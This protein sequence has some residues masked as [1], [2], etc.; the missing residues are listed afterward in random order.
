MRLV[1]QRGTGHRAAVAGM[2]IGGKTGTALK[3]KD[4]HYT[5]DVVNS[6]VAALPVSDPQYLILVT[7]DEPQPETQGK[8]SEAAYNAA[9]T[10]GALIKRIA[11]MLNVLPT[12]RFDETAAT[13]YEQAGS[14]D[15]QR[16]VLRKSPYETSG[17]DPG[18]PAHRQRKPA[19]S[20]GN[21]GPY[22]R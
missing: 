1:V 10:A 22:R 2:D 21:Y 16:A 17:F 12:P 15:P 4:G 19:P 6:F 7:L 18:Y 20:P 8:L 11:P 3:V 9:P 5:H 14:H 13:P